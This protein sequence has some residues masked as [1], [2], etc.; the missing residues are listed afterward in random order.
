[1]T[2]CRVIVKEDAFCVE[3]KEDCERKWNQLLTRFALAASMD[4]VKLRLD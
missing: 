3:D 2:A 1:M 4:E